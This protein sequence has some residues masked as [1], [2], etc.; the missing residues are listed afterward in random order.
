MEQD[1][2]LYNM[3]KWEDSIQANF[4]CFPCFFWYAN[5]LCQIKSKKACTYFEYCLQLRPLNGYLNFLY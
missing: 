5:F 2:K 3:N 4:K 1:V